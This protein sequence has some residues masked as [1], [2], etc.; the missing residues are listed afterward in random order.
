MGRR[1]AGLYGEY[2]A[3]GKIIWNKKRTGKPDHDRGNGVLHSRMCE[4]RKYICGCPGRR[5]RGT[6]RD[7][8][9][10]RGEIEAGF[11]RTKSFDADDRKGSKRFF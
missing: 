1:C 2:S 11:F 9:G 3:C 4:K 7:F 10:I 6:E 8:S 5:G